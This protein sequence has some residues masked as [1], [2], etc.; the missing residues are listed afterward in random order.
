MVSLE[1]A[2]TYI[3]YYKSKGLRS[4]YLR[5]I[6]LQVIED[7]GQGLRNSTV[8]IHSKSDEDTRSLL[9]ITSFKFFIF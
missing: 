5:G 6:L 8:I 1:K 7:V 2:P 3:S 4:P 9:T